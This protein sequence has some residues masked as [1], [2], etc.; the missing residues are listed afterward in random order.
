MRPRQAAQALRDKMA[1]Q[2]KTMVRDSLLR[3]MRREWALA[4]PAVAPIP[5]LTEV[6]VQ[7]DLD[8]MSM[9]LQ[10]ILQV[11]KAFPIRRRPHRRGLVTS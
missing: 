6:S 11:V 5:V 7:D 3:N 2:V 10:A 9:D 8:R 1:D 4:A